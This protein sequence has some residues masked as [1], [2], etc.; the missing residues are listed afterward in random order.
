MFFF[1]K[2]DLFFIPSQHYTHPYEGGRL[3]GKKLR[4][5]APK[6]ER[7]PWKNA[8]N[9]V[10][11]KSL[12]TVNHKI[13][14]IKKNYDARKKTVVKPNNTI[15]NLLVDSESRPEKT[16]HSALNCLQ[17]KPVRQYW[18]DKSW[19]IITSNGPITHAFL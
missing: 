12:I 16:K 18:L 8:K 6:Y 10:E 15:F 2:N 13:L 14:Y 7:V 19:P 4:W 11:I 3:H 9:E 17:G 5:W 1:I